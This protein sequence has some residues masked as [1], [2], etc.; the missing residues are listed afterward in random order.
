MN[1]ISGNIFFKKL[2]SEVMR[3]W[4]RIYG[5]KFGTITYTNLN[6]DGTVTIATNDIKEDLSQFT[7]TINKEIV[8][9]LKSGV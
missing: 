7:H 8:D 4:G 9:K 1:N 6:D 5:D 2:G 3:Y